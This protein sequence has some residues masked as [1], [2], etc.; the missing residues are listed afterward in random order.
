MACFYT[1]K[2]K[3]TEFTRKHYFVNTARCAVA[4]KKRKDNCANYSH[5]SVSSGDWFQDLPWIQNPWILQSHGQPS[6]P[7]DAE[8]MDNESRWYNLFVLLDQFFLYLPVSSVWCKNTMLMVPLHLGF[9]F[10][11]INK[12]DQQEIR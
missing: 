8:A 7:A 5:P 11:L 1:S 2:F 6:I 4:C 10:C 12:K 9:E 3:H